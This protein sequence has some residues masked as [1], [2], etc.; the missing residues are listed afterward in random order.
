MN[1]PLAPYID[2]EGPSDIAEQLLTLS[3]PWS[4]HF[5]LKVPGAFHHTQA[6][7]S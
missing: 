2:A 1:S 4:L 5:T 7:G 3:G 6:A